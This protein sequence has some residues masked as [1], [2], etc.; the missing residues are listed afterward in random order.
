MP[1]SY[2]CQDCEL[3]FSTGWYHYHVYADGYDACT[4]L[5]CARCGTQH[6]VEH[7]TPNR[8]PPV[9][10]LFGVE[11]LEHTAASEAMLRDWI[12]AEYGHDYGDGYE[13]PSPSHVASLLA[14]PLLEATE[15]EAKEM[16]ERLSV[17][18]ARAV[19]KL[20]R[21]FENEDYGPQRQSRLLCLPGPTIRDE[22]GALEPTTEFVTGGPETLTCTHCHELG[23]L[24]LSFAS[25][26]PCPRCREGIATAYR[27]WV[28]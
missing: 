21:V 23:S 10:R 4:L 12:T 6:A 25:P 24:V 26:G 22:L 2:V 17:L 20:L 9:Y 7:A 13:L 3:R 8:G 5:V 19:F 16:T 15:A 1:V 27:Q 14:K 28:T 11:V 18:G